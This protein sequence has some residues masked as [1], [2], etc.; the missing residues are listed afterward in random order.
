M[1]NRAGQRSRNKMAKKHDRLTAAFRRSEWWR[2][3]MFGCL[4]ALSA[5]LALLS[6]AIGHPVRNVVNFVA[7][8]LVLCFIVSFVMAAF[9]SI[10]FRRAANREKRGRPA[11]PKAPMSRHDRI[12]YVIAF[13]SAT[14]V[15]VAYIASFRSITWAWPGFVAIKIG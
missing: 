3:A 14:A 13:V 12:V 8:G 2:Y 6:T 11:Q 1:H 9:T 5:A 15:G 7:G 10:G 4:I